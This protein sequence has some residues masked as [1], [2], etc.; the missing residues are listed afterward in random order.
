MAGTYEFAASV[1][2][3][4]ADGNATLRQTLASFRDRHF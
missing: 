1:K 2:N 3:R 4:S